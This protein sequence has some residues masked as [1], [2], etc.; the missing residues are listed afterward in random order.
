MN[1]VIIGLGGRGGGA[2]GNFLEAAKTVGIDGKIVAVADI[3]P[4]AG[5]AR[6]RELWGAGR[7]MLQR[8][9]TAT[10][11]R[12]KCPGV[13]YAIIATPPG[14][15]PAQFKACV[16]AGKHTFTEKPVAT[17]GPGAASCTPRVNW[18]SRRA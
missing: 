12:W 10:R 18:P 4:D 5:Q 17:D 1:A 2:G 6:P 3:F 16:E 15:K 14:F 13:N 9:S 7:A 11:R 8:V